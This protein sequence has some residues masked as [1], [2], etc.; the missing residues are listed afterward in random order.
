MSDNLS[1]RDVIALTGRSRSTIYRQMSL[2]RFPRPEG[3]M[4]R[5]KLWRRDAV[6]Q[7]MGAAR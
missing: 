1:M 5:D 4:G 7:A 2:G 3:F 6:E